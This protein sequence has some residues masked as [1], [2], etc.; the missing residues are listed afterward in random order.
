MN[1]KNKAV[2]VNVIGAVESGGQIYGKR[3]YAAYADPYENTPNEHT[4]TLGWL[5]A[6]G[7]EA[8]RLIE[9]IYEADPVGAL[10]IDYDGTIALAWQENWVATRWKPSKKEKNILIGLI[11][12]QTGHK[13]QDQ[14][15]EELM[16]AFIEDCEADY[17]NDIKAQM[18][19]CEIRHLG[20][21]SAADRIFKRC[22][23]NFSLSNIMS[24]LKK[25]QN[26]SSSSNQ[27]GDKLFWS[28]HEKCKEFI[29][30]YAEEEE[31]EMAV[32]IGSARID[33]N[34]R[35]H[36]GTAGDQTGNEVSTQ[37]WYKHSKGWVVLRPKNAEDAEKIASAMQA[38]CDNPKIG[39]D[40]DQRYTLYDWLKAKGKGFD[41]ATV[42]RAVETD[43]SAL[44]RVCLASA[45]IMVGDFYTGNERDV[46]MATGKFTQLADDKAQV[47]LYLKRGDVLVTKVTGHTV[48]ALTNGSKADVEP[49]PEP[50]PTPNPT[51]VVDTKLVKQGQRHLNNFLSGFIADGRAEKL[52][53]DGEL[54]PKTLH[55]FTMAFQDAMNRSYGLHLEVDGVYGYYSSAAAYNYYT[56]P[57]QTS[58]VVTVL[59]IGMLLRNIN[60]KGVENPGTY[61]K[62]L[63]A[64]AMQFQG[65]PNF[66][67][68][69]WRRLCTS[70]S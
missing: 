69:G 51:P 12:S 28:R 6:Y 46:L 22:N 41:P 49:A 39:Y 19:Y 35:A 36:G 61:G 64:A 32:T 33:E 7:N 70:I 31:M 34:G 2:L 59:E 52:A 42:T 65:D 9:M 23:G 66:G 25:D 26:D 4:I 44:V 60:P 50:T 47:S 54:G 40:Q 53:V 18:M 45:G 62:G 16:D 15:F 43:C 24:A 58:Y 27:V 5:Q 67:R 37:N 38:A 63:E 56:R 68:E 10:N 20:G 55:N 14:M 29:D 3:N 1:K 11:D 30:K 48:V 13:C 17:T 57:G 21:K 8:Q